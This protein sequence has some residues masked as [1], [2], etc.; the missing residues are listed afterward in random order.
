MYNV[1]NFTIFKEHMNNY[2]VLYKISALHGADY[3]ECRI[4]GYRNP[5]RTVQE[6]LRLRYGAQQVTAT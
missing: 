1:Y 3:E 5:V 4:V 2:Y 6:T